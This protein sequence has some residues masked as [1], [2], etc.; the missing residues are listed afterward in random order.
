M[1]GCAQVSAQRT[2]A[3]LGHQ[4]LSDPNLEDRELFGR[5]RQGRPRLYTSFSAKSGKRPNP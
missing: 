4:S 3:N 1:D 5:P 2:V